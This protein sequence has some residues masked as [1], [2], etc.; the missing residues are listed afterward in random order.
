MKDLLLEIGVEEL[1]ARFIPMAMEQLAASGR[2]MLAAARLEP[3]EVRVSGTPRRL[4]LIAHGVRDVQPD[5]VREA[6]GPAAKIAFDPQG[7]PTRAAEGFAKGQG[8]PVTSLYRAQAEGGEY[9]FARVESKGRPAVEV[10]AALLPELIL[11]LSFPKAMRWANLDVRWARPIRWVVALLGAD[12]IPLEVA[13]VASGRETFGL[14]FLHPDPVAVPDPSHYEALL[15]DVHVLLDQ[16]ERSELIRSLVIDAAAR[17][18]GRVDEEDDELF[19]EVTY[20]N[21]FPSVVVGHFDKRYLELPIDVVVTPMR[22]HQRFFPVYSPDGRLLPVFITI[23]NGLPDEKG[24]VARGNEKVLAARLADA[25]F[26][27]EEDRKVRLED[28]LERLDTLVFQEK[29]GTVSARVGRIEKLA[30]FLCE[31]LGYSEADKIVAARAAHLSKSDLVTGMVFEFPELQGVMGKYYALAQGERPDV[32]TAI[33]EQYRPRFAGGPLP[34]TPAGRALALADKIDALTGYFAIGMVPSGSQDPFALRRATLGTIAILRD[35]RRP[36]NLE[37]MFS[38]AYELYGAVPGFKNDRATALQLL[39]DFLKARLRVALVEEGL[40]YDFVD[41]VL[42]SGETDPF[43]LSQR[44]QALQEY[45]NS[46]SFA[47]AFAAYV[48]A[49]NLASKAE[50]STI[51]PKALPEEADQNLLTA[52]QSAEKA[53][54]GALESRSVPAAIDA[55]AGLRRPLDAFFDAVLVMAPEDEVK[56]SRLAMLRAIVNLYSRLADWSRIVVEGAS[57][58]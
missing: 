22:H 19:E 31:Q 58:K 8:V 40:R 41:A 44:V 24:Y 18:G 46:S 45:S 2:S 49:S 6:K 10:L 52:C 53:F 3:T 57:G 39:A 54:D 37:V 17:E 42:A 33:D 28:R 5:E 38:R 21:E 36:V 25:A 23:R 47:D 20:I 35:A 13:G 11:S 51:D 27:Y 30:P 9:V 1:P 56:R 43:T 32:A 29:L 12:V 7:Q 14:R 55:L 4:T 48:R 15:R 34:E 16:R 26:F 50:T